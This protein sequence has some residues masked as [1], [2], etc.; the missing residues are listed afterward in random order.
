MDKPMMACGHAANARRGDG[1]LCCALCQTEK[2]TI[3]VDTPDLASRRARCSYH[4]TCKAESPSATNLP[5][6]RYRPEHAYDE[7]YCGCYGWD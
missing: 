2:S 3:I 4:S 5:F 6:F 1:T 7:Y